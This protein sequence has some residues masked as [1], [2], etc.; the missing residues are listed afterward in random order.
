MIRVAICDD[1]QIV[2]QGFKTIVDGM[3]DISVSAE[4]STGRGALEIARGNQCD[5]MLLDI[6]MPEQN[7]IDVLRSIKQGQPNF[8]V[9][10]LS[11]CPAKQYALS[12]LKIGADGYLD[13]ACEPAEMARAIRTVARGRRYLGPETADIVAKCLYENSD[14]ALHTKLSD[15]EFQVF[16]HLCKG[17]SVSEIAERLFLSIKT[18]STYRTRVLE[19]MG[20]RSN[21]ELTY[22][23]VKNELIA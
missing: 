2:R 10:M 12:T 1:H 14:V 18:V 9:V 5:V 4:A 23:A 17:D 15:R 20:M 8:P 7:G 13:K 16:L 6:N 3:D 19:K 21:S 22:Y 11:T